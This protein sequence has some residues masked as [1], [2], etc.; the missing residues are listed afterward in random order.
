MT[1]DL[2]ESLNNRQKAERHL[3]LSGVQFNGDAVFTKQQG[4]IGSVTAMGKNDKRN[5][6]N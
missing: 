1:K 4:M 6:V 3:V 5:K 2:T